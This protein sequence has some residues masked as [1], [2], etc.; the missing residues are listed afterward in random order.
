MFLNTVIF[1]QKCKILT[2]SHMEGSILSQICFFIWDSSESDLT[3][4]FSA[5]LHI[6][7]CSYFSSLSF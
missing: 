7:N 4:N 1:L 5:A 6:F 3:E 2:S